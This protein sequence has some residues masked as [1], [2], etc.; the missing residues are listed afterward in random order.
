MEG[1]ASRA[2]AE[3]GLFSARKKDPLESVGV[4][5]EEE[6]K[7]LGVMEGAVGSCLV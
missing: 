2:Q 7:V 3:V 1:T 5:D 6:E 4:K